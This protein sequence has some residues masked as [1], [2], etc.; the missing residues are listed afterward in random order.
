MS[1]KTAR[2]WTWDEW[3]DHYT[4]PEP[5]TG[6]LLYLLGPYDRYGMAWINGKAIGAHRVPFVLRCIPIP[7]GAVVRHSCDTPA[8]VNPD[9]LSIGTQSENYADSFRRGR[10]QA[11]IHRG[12]CAN[13]HDLSVVGTYPKHGTAHVRCRACVSNHNRAKYLRKHPKARSFRKTTVS[14]FRG[15]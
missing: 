15:N 9:H 11:L 8:C 2:L 7:K 6:C 4:V 14:E 5:N 12:R 1:S 13:G 3:R 10:T